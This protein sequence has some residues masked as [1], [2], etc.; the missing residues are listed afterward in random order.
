MASFYG[1]KQGITYHIVERYDQIFFDIDNQQYIKIIGD[2]VSNI[3]ENKIFE[4]Q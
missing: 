1:G 3:Q 4:T 2:V